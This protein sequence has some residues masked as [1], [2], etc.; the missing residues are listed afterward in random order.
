MTTE[1]CRTVSYAQ[2][3]PHLAENPGA[4]TDP[5]YTQAVRRATNTSIDI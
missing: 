1:Q 5:P 3:Q 4:K 2:R